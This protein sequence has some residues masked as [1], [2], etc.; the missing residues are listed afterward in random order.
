MHGANDW[1][2]IDKDEAHCK[3]EREKAR[4]LRKSAWWK[5]QISIKK[6]YY[7]KQSFEPSELTMDH[8]LPIVRGGESVKKNCVPACKNCNNNK[9]Y[10]TPAEIIM[11]QI[12]AE[13]QKRSI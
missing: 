3:R 7:C 2:N 1:V 13:N 5:H 12:N 11:N 4:A 10:L 6:C 9:K 8:I